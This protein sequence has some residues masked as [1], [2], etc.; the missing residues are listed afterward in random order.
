MWYSCEDGWWIVAMTVVGRRPGPGV[1]SALSA[2]KMRKA[3]VESR[4]VARGG[5]TVRPSF[6]NNVCSDQ[7]TDQK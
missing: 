6:E 1:V 3:E 2:V 7:G 5:G 4:P